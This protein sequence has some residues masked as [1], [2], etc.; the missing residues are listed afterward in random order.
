MIVMK[1]E[2]G[3]HMGEIWT[4]SEA[5]YGEFENNR[6]QTFVML[7]GGKKIYFRVFDRAQS[8][9]LMRV[10]KDKKTW[11]N[12]EHTPVVDFPLRLWYTK[13]V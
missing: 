10:L 5:W 4:A 1:D 11:L 2:Y 9:S 12:I 3:N 6:A 7:V 13:E 8:A